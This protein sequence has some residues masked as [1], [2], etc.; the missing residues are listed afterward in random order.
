MFLDYFTFR[1]FSHGSCV[2]LEVV[3]IGINNTGVRCEYEK[4]RLELTYHKW[5]KVSKVFVNN[6][7]IVINIKTSVYNLFGTTP[8]FCLHWIRLESITYRSTISLPRIFFFVCLVFSKP[9]CLYM[10]DVSSSVLYLR[11]VPQP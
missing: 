5:K 4:C 11:S 1:V 9:S 2:I 8:F 10:T 3:M 6:S 7:W